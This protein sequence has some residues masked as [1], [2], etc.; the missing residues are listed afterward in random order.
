MTGMAPATRGRCADRVKGHMGAEA[1]NFHPRA[2]IPAADWRVAR[3]AR[4]VRPVDGS[5]ASGRPAGKDAFMRIAPD[6]PLTRINHQPMTADMIVSRHWPLRRMRPGCR[7]SHDRPRAELPGLAPRQHGPTKRATPA[8][9]PG[10][11]GPERKVAASAGGDG[12][13][14]LR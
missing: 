7:G 3:T 9:I 8:G 2:P 4:P 11:D 13:G 1:R 12:R 5:P 14:P 6:R 10:T